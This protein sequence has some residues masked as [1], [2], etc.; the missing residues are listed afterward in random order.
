MDLD[1]LARRYGRRPSELAGYPA[2]HPL[3]LSLDRA[4]CEVGLEAEQR[5]V[6][7]N[8]E[9]IQPVYVMGSI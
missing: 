3:A 9:G 2:D 1:R 6:R 4:A 7:R 8:G 5:L